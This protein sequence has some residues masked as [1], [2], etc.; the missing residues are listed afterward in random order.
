MC[1]CRE[2]DFSEKSVQ[3]ARDVAGVDHLESGGDNCSVFVEE[4]AA[5]RDRPNRCVWQEEVKHLLFFLRRELHLICECHGYFSGDG[6]ASNLFEGEVRGDLGIDGS[7]C[8]REAFE[9]FVVIGNDHVDPALGGVARFV[10]R[11]D[12]VVDCDDE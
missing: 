4:R 6:C 1:L 7:V 12:T 11:C 3:A 10:D 5:I 2:S 8:G 9:C